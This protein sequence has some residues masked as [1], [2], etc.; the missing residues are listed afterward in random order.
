MTETV[1]ADINYIAPMD[2]RP[3]YHANDFTKDVLDPD[4][5]P[6]DIINARTLEDAPQFGREGFA[7]VEHKS[8]VEDFSDPKAIFEQHSREIADLVKQLTGADEVQVTSPGLLRFG[9]KSGKAGSLNNSRPARFAHVDISAA[10]AHA[11]L[12]TSKPEGRMVRRFAHVNVWRA[13]SPAPQDVPL[14]LCDGRSVA[15]KDLIPGEAVFDEPGKPNWSFEG[16]VVAHNP[17]HRWC[18]YKDM[19][20]DEV[21]VFYTYDSEEGPASQVPHVAFNDPS[22]PEDAEP[23]VS[24]E[25]RAT[26]YWLE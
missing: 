19:N 11:M 17:A 4:I 6:M 24:L 20:R 13:L 14:A 22:C 10:T 2:V 8:A 16:L 23:R 9:E 18:Y 3:V 26:A 5:R 15:A 21:L 1:T 12:E 25:M 7:L